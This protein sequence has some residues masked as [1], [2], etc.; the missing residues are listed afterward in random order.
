MITIE[1]FKASASRY[2]R[3]MAWTLVGSVLA[4]IA[5]MGLVA[6]FR[7]PLRDI[8]TRTFGEPAAEILIGLSPLPAVVILLGSLWYSEY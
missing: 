2:S 4:V 3:C 7:D 1:E 8:Y 5:F 6:R